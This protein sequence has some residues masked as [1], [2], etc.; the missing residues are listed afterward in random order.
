MSSRVHALLVRCGGHPHRHAR[1]EGFRFGHDRVAGFIDLLVM[2]ARAGRI[3][4]D[5]AQALFD[6]IDTETLAKLEDLM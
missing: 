3:A 1:S 5:K 2:Q 6:A 4:L